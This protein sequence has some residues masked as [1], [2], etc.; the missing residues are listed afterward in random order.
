MTRKLR[1]FKDQLDKAGLK[2]LPRHELEPDIELGDLEVKN[3]FSSALS[4][5]NSLLSIVMPLLFG[6]V[7][8]IF[9]L[10]LHFSF[11]L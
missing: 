6:C 2:C 5:E 7:D 8:G 3:E 9:F 11:Y 4:V 1:F 10:A